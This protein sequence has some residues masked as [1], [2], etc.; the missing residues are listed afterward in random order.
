[1]AELKTRILVVDDDQRL[2]DLLVKYLSGEGFDVTWSQQLDEGIPNPRWTW[3]ACV[4]ERTDEPI[5]HWSA[6]YKEPLLR[7]AS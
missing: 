3:W 7:S 2:R 4:A 1:M 6:H 5:V